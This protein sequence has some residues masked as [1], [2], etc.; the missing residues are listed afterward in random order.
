[1]VQTVLFGGT[2]GMGV[3]ALAI[4]TGLMY[5]AKQE[6]QSA[7]DSAAL[8]AAS[9]LGATSDASALA[10]AEAKRFA[11]LND[12][13]GEDADLV[14]ADVVFGHAVLDGTKYTFQ[15]GADPKD[16]V[17]VTLKRDQTVSDGPVSLLF[18]KTF[19]MTG[20]RMQA[21]AVAMLVPRDISMIVD[22][23]GSMNDDSEL[24]H[25]KRFASEKSGYID[26]VQINLKA[27]WTALPQ[28]KGK[29]GVKNGTNPS[30]P[31]SPVANDN[32]PSNG[33][34]R[35]QS[36]GGNPDPNEETS[37]G[38]SN[39]KGPRW[40]WMTDYGTSLV[41][42]SYNPSS[43]F[44]LYYIPKGSTCSD[45][46]V[47]AN[48]TESGYS[49]SE[50]SA[51]LSGSSDSDTNAYK[52]R[53]QV[54]LG[55]AGWK[56]GKSG[57]K[58][59][60]GGNGDN[61]VDSNELTNTVS[62]PFNSGSWDGYVDYMRSSST[63]MENTDSNLK[64]RFGIKTFVNFLLEQQESHSETPELAN[65]PE[66]PLYS[67][68]NA[69]QTMIDEI[70]YLE[71]QD[72]VSLETFAQYSQHRV[73]LTQVTSGESLA[74]KLQLVADNCY[75]YQAGHDT[76]YTN[77]GA[78]LNQAITELMS[79]RARTAASKVIILL[80]DGKP[81]VDSNGSVVGNNAAGAISWVEDRADFAKSKGFTVYTVG[82]G[83]DVDDELLSDAATSPD[84]Y[85]YADNAPDPDNGNA[86]LY[87]NQLKQ[88]FK[89]LGGKRPVRLIQ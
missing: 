86:P 11:K 65:T 51:L 68:K 70:I 76:A 62:Y 69:V 78:G 57:G 85:Y 32:Q 66:E 39:P 31:G 77:I 41:L 79:E 19:G 55:L 71:T 44:G 17:R 88:I 22:L 72:H 15:P 47:V 35:P 83:G 3:A 75:T 46:D 56:S 14:D 10:T 73:D 21:S 26:G 61:K 64:Y 53:V 48:L 2:V 36:A 18:A 74:A 16:A 54:L 87:V 42:G 50:R 84:H 43:D 45:S 7:A 58:Y 8:A 37:G 20:A 80:T 4:D 23:S 9:Q 6:L 30:S 5:S 49:S 29:A 34:G 13:M 60:T 67:V 38:S 40:G 81:N 24:R 59:T 12:V 33:T 63:Q 52:R 25:Y 82:V 27:V 1:M 89:T 28:N